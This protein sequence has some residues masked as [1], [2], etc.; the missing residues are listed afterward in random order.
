MLKVVKVIVVWVKTV[1]YGLIH[2]E[3]W[4]QLTMFRDWK[5]DL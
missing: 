4:Q 2:G 1:C 5:E 3:L